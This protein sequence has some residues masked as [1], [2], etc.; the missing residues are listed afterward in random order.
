MNILEVSMTQF[1]CIKDLAILYIQLKN[2]DDSLVLFGTQVEE[3]KALVTRVVLYASVGIFYF[4]SD[5]RIGEKNVKRRE[6]LQSIFEA[7]GLQ[8]NQNANALTIPG[9]P[10]VIIDHIFKDIPFEKVLNALKTGE[11]L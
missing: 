6:R 3:K 2:K 1:K 4:T 7:L 10:N 5:D 9:E 11:S 8:K